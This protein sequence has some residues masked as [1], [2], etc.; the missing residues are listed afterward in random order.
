M[1]KPKGSCKYDHDRIIKLHKMG[2]S[3]TTIAKRMGCT[4]QLVGM[5]VREHRREQG[6]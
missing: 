6:Q 4:R 5:V 2:L 3:Q 1:G